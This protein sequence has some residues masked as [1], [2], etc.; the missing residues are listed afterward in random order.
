MGGKGDIP[1]PEAWLQ[2]PLLSGIVDPVLVQIDLSW[3]PNGQYIGASGYAVYRSDNGGSF[4]AISG[5]LPLTQT[6]LIDAALVSTHNYTY[7]VAV[8]YPTGGPILSNKITINGSVLDVFEVGGSLLWTKR[9]GLRSAVVTAIGAGA[10]GVSGS[11]GN[12][13]LLSMGAGGGG[14]F[15][16]ATYTAA[17]LPATV[18]IQVGV[19]GQ[20]AQGVTESYDTTVHPGTAG[21][22]GGTSSFGTLV[23]ATGG[24]SVV[25]T[26]SQ[27]PG[28]TGTVTG[29]G[30]NVTTEA[31]GVGGTQS[32]GNTLSQNGTGGATTNA[33]GGG[34]AGQGCAND[35]SI[36]SGAGYANPGGAVTNG[37]T[38]GAYGTPDFL[39]P[40]NTTATAGNGANGAPGATGALPTGGGGGGG[41]GG[42][43][44]ALTG[45]VTAGNGGN[46]GFPGGGGGGGGTPN[47]NAW[48]NFDALTSTSGNGGNGANG[49]VTVETF[50]W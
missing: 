3:V 7:Y 44:V 8:I 28:G 22:A 4:V 2:G 32:Y 15:A 27:S 38:G 13:V 21:A 41:G 18:A 25:N 45:P 40:A 35:A 5:M 34:G 33:P 16:R 43:S 19:G 29:G 31:G 20:G 17:Q 36:N 42:A 39:Y 1:N 26:S 11:Y 14:G 30:T 23:V 10:G 46:G 50:F 9:S 24:T 37:G 12:A 48:G 49:Q 47:N 6:T